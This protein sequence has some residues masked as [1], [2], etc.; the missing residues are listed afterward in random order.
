MPSTSSTRTCRPG[1]Q[2]QDTCI[3][4]RDKNAQENGEPRSYNQVKPRELVCVCVCVYAFTACVRACLSSTCIEGYDMFQQH[5][6]C[7]HWLY[8]RIFRPTVEQQQYHEYNY[9]STVVQQCT[10]L[11]A[12]VSVK[13]SGVWRQLVDRFVGDGERQSTCRS[14]VVSITTRHTRSALRMIQ[15]LL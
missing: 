3:S 15:L 8:D 1:I 12:A 9:S 13:S 6:A 7:P 10:F 5:G 2:R 4:M 11:C 14:T